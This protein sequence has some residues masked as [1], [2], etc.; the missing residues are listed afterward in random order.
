MWRTNYIKDK[1][2]PYP[3]FLTILPNVDVLQMPDNIFII[4][5]LFLES[6]LSISL[7][8]LNFC[9]TNYCLLRKTTDPL[10]FKDMQYNYETSQN[11]Q[12]AL[13]N[14]LILSLISNNA[15]NLYSVICN[16][17]IKWKE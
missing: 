12:A 3:Q 16:S 13:Q 15:P 7:K 2:L 14:N 8:Q 1:I 9:G 11:I 10:F 5:F 6:G 17:T 4:V